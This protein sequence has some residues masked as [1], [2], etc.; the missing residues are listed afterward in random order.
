MS[1]QKRS[2]LS[3][4]LGYFVAGVLAVLPVV[5]TFAVVAWVTDYVARFVGPGSLVG[6]GLQA[7][8]LRVVEND[9]LAYVVGWVLVLTIV[10]AL[11]LMVELGAKR[12]LQSIVDALL[13]RVPIVSSIYGTS[14]QLIG[15]L[16]KKDEADLQ[17]MR[18]VFCLFGNE[19]PT[20]VLALLTSPE[21]FKIGDDEYHAVIIP[22]A[23][24]PI[25]G[26]LVFVP[27]EKVVSVDVSV[28][29]LMSVYVS[30]GVT[31][32]EFLSVAK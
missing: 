16:D 5:I 12:M 23:P 2:L 28:D 17:G 32:P 25:G 3:R 15:M 30:M 6:N 24:V 31:A 18:S 9:T 29:G 1:L 13:T 27:V 21:R 7:F 14:K 10:F 20:A 11:G 22:T 4:L 26:G 8:G 19:K